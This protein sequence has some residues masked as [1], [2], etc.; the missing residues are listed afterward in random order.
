MTGCAWRNLRSIPS[1]ALLLLLLTHNRVSRLLNG[2]DS[3]K[4]N[5]HTLFNPSPP[6]VFPGCWAATCLNDDKYTTTS[7]EH[8]GDSTAVTGIQL[9]TP[10]GTLCIGSIKTISI[11]IASVFESMVYCLYIH[12]MR[13]NVYDDIAHRMDVD[14]PKNSVVLIAVHQMGTNERDKC[15]Q[16]SH[17][18]AFMSPLSCSTTAFPAGGVESA[19][20][21]CKLVVLLVFAPLALYHFCSRHHG[22]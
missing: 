13:H 17:I 10:F 8:Q 15:T 18:T 12:F 20:W 3:G 6:Y 11:F 21:L 22:T 19:L 2:N 14:K 7:P 16:Y 5:T 4:C 1:Q 9:S